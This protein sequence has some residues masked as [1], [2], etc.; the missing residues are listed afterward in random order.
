MRIRLRLLIRAWPAAPPGRRSRPPAQPRA[1]RGAQPA[2]HILILSHRPPHRELTRQE[3]GSRDHGRHQLIGLLGHPVAHSLSPTMQN[4]AFAALAPRL[5]LRAARR[6][7][8]SELEDA[9]RGSSRSAS[10]APT[11]RAPH[12]VAVGAA[13]HDRRAVQ[14]TPWSSGTGVIHGS[15]D[16]RGD[17]RGPVAGAARHRRGRRRGGS[18]SGRRWPHA[19]SYSRRDRLGRPTFGTPIS[20]STRASRAGTRSLFELEAHQTLVRPAVSR[21]GNSGSGA[22]G[23]CDRRR[24][25]RRLV[26]S[27]RGGVR[28]LDRRAGARCGGVAHCAGWA[29]RESDAALPRP[30][31]QAPDECLPFWWSIEPDAARCEPGAGGSAGDDLALLG[32]ETAGSGRLRESALLRGP[33]IVLSEIDNRARCDGAARSPPIRRQAVVRSLAGSSP[34][35]ATSPW[36]P[37][38]VRRGSARAVRRRPRAGHSG[39]GNSQPASC[40]TLAARS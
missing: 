30:V 7:R 12:K 23:R 21:D 39:L 16:R 28:A 37:R 40:E 35:P 4:A 24:R 34:P 27:G 17:P 3:R 29:G 11:S 5:R 13:R 38:S 2:G 33:A 31:S 15:L 36:L 22:G 6:G 20:S 26:C 19:R 14:S 8:P 32:A 18:R 10:P 25:R 9:L 1:A